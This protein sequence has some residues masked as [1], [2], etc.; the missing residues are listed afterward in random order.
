MRR[1][2]ALF[3]DNAIGRFD[4]RFIDGVSY[5]G[6]HCGECFEVKVFSIWEPTRIEYCH[7]SQD[8]YLVGLMNRIDVISGL[9]VRM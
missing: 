2:G 7:E 8:W 3:Y 6:L 5:G 4:I 9:P 1:E